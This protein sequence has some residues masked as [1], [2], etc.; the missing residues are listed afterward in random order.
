MQQCYSKQT[1]TWIDKQTDAHLHYSNFIEWK[2]KRVDT[3][4]IIKSHFNIYLFKYHTLNKNKL[5]SV[6]Q[7]SQ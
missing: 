7:K 2:R 3:N 4:L 5:N 1:V 6:L